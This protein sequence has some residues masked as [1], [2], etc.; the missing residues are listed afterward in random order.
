MPVGVV[1]INHKQAD[2]S[3]REYIAKQ[4]QKLFSP[5]KS[6]HLHG[7]HKHYFLLI[8]TCNRTEIYF[9][10]EDTSLTHSYIISL[11]N[12]YLNE[13][14]QKF[15]S[16]FG[17]K[18]HHHLYRVVSGLDSAVIGET[19]IQGQIK[20]SYEK[21]KASITFPKA[22]HF[23]FQKALHTGKK[24]RHHF[25]NE[26]SRPKIEQ[27]IFSLAQKHT[28]EGTP[29]I[30]FLGAS[31]INKKILLYFLQ[32]KYGGIT[33]CNRTDEKALTLQNKY[34]INTLPWKEKGRW[35]EF[36][37][38]IAGTHAQ[39]YLLDQHDD[40]LAPKLLLDLSMP[41]NIDPHLGL[42]QGISLYNIDQINKTLKHKKKLIQTMITQSEREALKKA[43]KDHNLMNSKTS[44]QDLIFM[45]A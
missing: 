28:F 12:P 36:D 18:C 17:L 37:I 21:A 5:E 44:K 19:E 13:K 15:Y 41:R 24:L 6:L 7:D 10:S 27:A 23:L 26:Y 3:L 43:Q 16:F 39:E 20:Q 14:T 29:N 34:A 22:F 35:I 42:T 2:V 25:L 1:G 8:N 30:L 33:L 31:E 32:K 4:C 9:S 11:L 40:L 45:S 38:V